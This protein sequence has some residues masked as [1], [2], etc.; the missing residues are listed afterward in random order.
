MQCP[1]NSLSG[2]ATPSAY[3][4]SSSPSLI[5]VQ[6]VA[7]YNAIRG[8]GNNNPI[9]LELIGGGDIGN[10][11]SGPDT[12]P[13]LTAASYNTM[14]NVIWDLHYYGNSPGDTSYSG[15]LATIASYV[16]QIQG[17]TTSANGTIPVFF[18]EYGDSL[19]GDTVDS[20]GTNTVKA[21][22]AAGY[23]ATAWAWN[24]GSASD[25]LATSS[26]VLTTYG[27]EVA[28]YIAG[29]DTSGFTSIGP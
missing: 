3:A 22:Q 9:L 19:S 12:G 24:A 18:G 4:S 26:S 17:F 27:Q 14:T 5:T 7:T 28:A 1:V 13:Y 8:A 21:I 15:Q 16:A 25:R 2:V 10:N 23:G 20:Y 29:A 6:Q 11:A